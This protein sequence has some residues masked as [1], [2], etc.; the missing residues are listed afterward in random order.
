MQGRTVTDPFGILIEWDGRLKIYLIKI[1]LPKE[2][3]FVALTPS[4]RWKVQVSRQRTEGELSLTPKT[5]NKEVG[6]DNYKSWSIFS[7]TF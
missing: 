1:Q 2:M 4:P 3:H 5:H 6:L 7:D